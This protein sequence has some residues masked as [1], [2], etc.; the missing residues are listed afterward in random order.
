MASICIDECKLVLL[1]YLKRL[2]LEKITF[3]EKTKKSSFFFFTH[4]KTKAKNILNHTHL[5]MITVYLS[6][7]LLQSIYIFYKTHFFIQIYA[8]I[9]LSICKVCSCNAT[10]FEC[11][12]SICPLVIDFHMTTSLLF[13]D[14]F[15][16]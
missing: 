13:S 2:H 10:L 8:C 1:N 16:G 4:L 9:Y 11:I 15:S 6:Q 14:I 12:F 5:Y 7:T 3:Y